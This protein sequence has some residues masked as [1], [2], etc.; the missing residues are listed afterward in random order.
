MNQN[1]FLIS[2]KKTGSSKDVGVFFKEEG[3]G[4]PF[5]V[6]ITVPIVISLLPT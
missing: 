2:G 5:I 4:G 1:P 6:A 3:I